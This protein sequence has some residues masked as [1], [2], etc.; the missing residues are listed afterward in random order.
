MEQWTVIHT[1]RNDKDS[2]YITII[3]IDTDGLK[4]EILR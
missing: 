1:I 3:Y 4:L 2:K